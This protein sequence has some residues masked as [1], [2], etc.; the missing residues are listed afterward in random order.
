MASLFTTKNGDRGQTR[1]I[2][3]DKVSK[4]HP[5]VECTGALDSFRARLAEARL[6][7]IER[8]VPDAQHHTEF[9]Y[10]LLHVCFVIGTE[11]ND[12]QAKKPEYRIATL[13]EAHLKRLEEEQARIEAG[14]NLPRAF[15]VTATTSL[16]ARFD[17]LAT[18]VRVLERAIVRLSETEPDFEVAQLLAFT[19]RMSDYLVALARGLE[20]GARQPVDYKVVTGE[21]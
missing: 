8:G 4:S 21:H 15:I 1:L 16:A 13:G 12:P 9:L 20:S 5:A 18:D 3:G 14:L 11:V 6:L 7:L 17:V 2:S 19:N 10:W